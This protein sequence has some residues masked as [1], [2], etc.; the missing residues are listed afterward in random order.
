MSKEVVVQNLKEQGYDA[1]I[2]SGVIMVNVSDLKQMQE[3]KSRLNELGYNSSY[4]VIE[5]KESA[6]S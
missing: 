6:I 5:R 2:D 1:F 4:G 3:I